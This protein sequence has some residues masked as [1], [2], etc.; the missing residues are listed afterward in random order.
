[1]DKKIIIINGTGGSGKDT[2]VEFCSKYANVFNFSSIDK[3]KEIAKIIGWTGSKS[4]KDRKFLSD[5]K[6]LTTEYND[7]AFNSIKDAINTFN[8]SDMDVMFIHIREPEEIKRAVD[9]FGAKTLL[10]K[11]DGLANIE[12][13][14]SD[15]SVDNYNYD[16]VIRN[17]TLEELDE[18]ADKFIEKLNNNLIRKKTK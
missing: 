2:F 15:A 7:M 5:L 8:N 16:Y 4:E 1:M 9:T 6:K 12:S 13:N 18:K 17:T 10:V 14:Y 3:V 11:R